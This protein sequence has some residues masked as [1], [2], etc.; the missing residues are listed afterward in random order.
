MG[1]P[2]KEDKWVE[3]D[4]QVISGCEKSIEIAAYETAKIRKENMKGER[5]YGFSLENKSYR[6]N[7]FKGGVKK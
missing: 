4:K 2:K 5:G 6:A 1:R 7:L 3:V